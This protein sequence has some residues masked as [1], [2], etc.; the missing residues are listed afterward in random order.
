MDVKCETEVKC[1]VVWYSL[2]RSAG[3]TTLFRRTYNVVLPSLPPPSAPP[4]HPPSTQVPNM[5][6]YDER[7]AVLEQ[8]RQRS[9][10]EGLALDS[11]V[12]LWNYFVDKT[13][14]VG[15]GGGGCVEGEL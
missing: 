12:E 1:T 3:P 10:K 4:P 7:A 11:A 2:D 8:C 9:K 14:E 13:R 15:D 6:P 5:F